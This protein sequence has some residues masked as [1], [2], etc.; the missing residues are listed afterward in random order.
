MDVFV[1]NGLK[2]LEINDEMKDEM[3]E[4]IQH[5]LLDQMTWKTGERTHNKL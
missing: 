1:T 4:A 3:G 2:E 5:T